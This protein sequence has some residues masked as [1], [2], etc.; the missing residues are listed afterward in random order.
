MTLM[1]GETAF[2][3]SYASASSATYAPG[4]AL[5]PSGLN[6]GIQK[7]LRFGSLPMMKSRML[8]KLRASDAA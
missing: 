8:G 5:E 6:C 7:R 2:S 3:A 4:E 1:R